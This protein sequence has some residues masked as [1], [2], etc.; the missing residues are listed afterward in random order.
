MSATGRTDTE[1]LP[2]DSPAVAEPAASPG[3][4]LGRVVGR[5]V[6]FQPTWIL[7]SLVVM[8][9]VFSVMRPSEFLTTFNITSLAVDASVLLVLSIGQ[10]F[11]IIS[12]GIDLS[13]G[14]VLVFSGVIAVKVMD[15][16]GGASGGLGTIVLGLLIAIAAG[17]A[18]GAVNGVLIAKAR[19]PQLI[20]TLGT[21]GMA[22]GFAEIITNGTDIRD[23]P[24]Q[25]TTSI[26]FGKLGPV[27]W[28]V[29]IALALT[30]LAGLLLHTTRF[31]LRTRAI[32]SN[33]EA[34][35]RVAVRVDRH[36][37]LVYALSGF[38]AGVAG[39]L[40]LAQFGTTTIA[41][42]STDNLATITAV[43]LGGA[44]LFG[45]SGMMIG[46]VI[47]VLL[48]T[49]LTNGLIIVGVQP[50]WQGVAIGAVLIVA[51]YID[52]HRRS[53]QNR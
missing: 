47:G 6:A 1:Q 42:H 18:W 22:F 21:L 4:L 41:G 25:L 50:F 35:R 2:I 16:L 52:Q 23:V 32:G 13:V 3:L 44:S 20:T 48:P 53:A 36:L 33:A 26:G 27:P 12:A 24:T 39:F 15:R 37:I 28:L 10:T 43:V 49:V 40:S 14:A 11:V 31:G 8:I 30:V 38:C 7:L 5:C 51:V 9:V 46:T 34:V 19:V 29:L 17:V 45:G